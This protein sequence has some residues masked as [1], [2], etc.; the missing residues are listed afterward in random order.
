MLFMYSLLSGKS[1]DLFLSYN[2]FFFLVIFLCFLILVGSK[3]LLDRSLLAIEGLA[4]AV[5]TL[6]V[7]NALKH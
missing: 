3:S 2:G 4:F 5:N 7:Q 1:K 6:F